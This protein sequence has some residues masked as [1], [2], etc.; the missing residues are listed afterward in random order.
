MRKVD[1]ILKADSC[2][3]RAQNSELIFV[4]LER[5]EAAPIAIQSWIEARVRL[6]KNSA[7]DSQIIEA[8][9]ILDQ[10]LKRRQS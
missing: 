5:D 9:K 2:F 3:N 8:R 4:L 6:G 7:D 1:E 10:M